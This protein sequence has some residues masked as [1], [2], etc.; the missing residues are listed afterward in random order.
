MVCG[1]DGENEEDPLHTAVYWSIMIKTMIATLVKRFQGFYRVL[2]D[3]H[4]FGRGT[5]RARAVVHTVVGW[6]LIA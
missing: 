3:R 4:I 2:A 6:S 1:G 5:R